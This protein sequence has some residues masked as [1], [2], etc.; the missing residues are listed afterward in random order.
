MS[1]ALAMS[2]FVTVEPAIAGDGHLLVV[3]PDLPILGRDDTD[4]MNQCTRL[5]L[6]CYQGFQ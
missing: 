3:R 6:A 2:S 1:L 4:R 5:P